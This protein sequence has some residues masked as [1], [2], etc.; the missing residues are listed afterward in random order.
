MLNSIKDEFVTAELSDM[1]LKQS[2]YDFF[3]VII[4]KLKQCFIRWEYKS[5]ETGDLL[6]NLEISRI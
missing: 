4:G 2:I 3:L 6:P 5:H 1:W